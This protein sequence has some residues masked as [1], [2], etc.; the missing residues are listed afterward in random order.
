[1]KAKVSKT[2][3]IVAIAAIGVFV[4]LFSRSAAIEAAYPFQRVK[5]WLSRSVCS[6]I[7]GAWNGAAASAENERLKGELSRL[8]LENSES[9]NIY[10][11]NHRL[12]RALGYARKNRQVWIPAEVLSCGGGAADAFKSVR[13]GKGSLDGVYEGAV[14]EVP[15]GL[16]GRV[17]SVTPHTSEV[18]LI[19]DPSVKVACKID[20]ET[21]VTGILSGGTEESLSIR[22]LKSGPVI[23]PGTKVYTSGSGEIFP[24]G[25]AVGTFSTDVKAAEHHA[26]GL[27]RRGGVRPAVDFTALK[28]VFIRKK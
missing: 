10:E 24:P 26:G 28:D 14:V 19:T 22:F 20:A 11:E 3:A 7:S 5:L 25:I 1:M 2:W 16:V 21:P 23:R 12:R 17:I 4:F 9:K 15:D 6:R 13:V 8:V 18:M 27:E